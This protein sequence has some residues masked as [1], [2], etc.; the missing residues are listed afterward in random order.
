NAN[1]SD[2]DAL[3][4]SRFGI[5]DYSVGHVVGVFSEDA[6]PFNSIDLAHSF[7]IAGLNTGEHI[8]AVHDIR[9]AV[10]DWATVK[11]RSQQI[12]RIH[13]TAGADF[14]RAV[15]GRIGVRRQASLARD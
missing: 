4:F 2:T 11:T 9:L 14:G 12:A 5:L 8:F 15:G 6:L 1:A 3:Q 10:H 7:V 13:I